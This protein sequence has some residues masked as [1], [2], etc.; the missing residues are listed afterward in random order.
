M[1]SFFLWENFLEVDF[2]GR[3]DLLFERLM[4]IDEFREVDS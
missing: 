1:F 3:A 4:S 2:T